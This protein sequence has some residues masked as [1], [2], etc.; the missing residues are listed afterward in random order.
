M[1]L[2]YVILFAVL[3][4]GIAALI[5][6]KLLLPM[7]HST[8]RTVTLIVSV[9]GTI[10]CETLLILAAMI[11]SKVDTMLTIG[12]DAVETHFESVQPGYVNKELSTLELENVLSNTKMI[13][14]FIDERPEASLAVQLIGAG[15]YISYIKTFANTLQR[16]IQ[17]MKDAEIPITLHNVLMRIQDLSRPAVLKWTKVLEILVLILSAVFL[18]ALVII[19]FIFT[20]NE[21]VVSGPCVVVSNDETQPAQ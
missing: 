9:F 7:K 19:Y 2:V 13:A 5:F 11:P 18:L 10:L 16:H 8:A 3:I 21:D 12:I 14:S 15:T 17:D 1:K 6:W 4:A 20:K